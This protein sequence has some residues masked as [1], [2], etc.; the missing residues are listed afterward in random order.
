MYGGILYLLIFEFDLTM[1]QKV[2]LNNDFP[3]ILYGLLL[4][5]SWKCI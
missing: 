4:V 2:L 5:G 1:Q 3:Y